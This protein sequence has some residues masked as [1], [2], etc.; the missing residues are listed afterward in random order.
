MATDKKKSLKEYIFIMAGVLLLA[1]S[2]K[3]FL[4]PNSLVTG[5]ATGL[6][7]IGQNI[8]QKYFGFTYPLWLSNLIIN[9]PLFIIAAK[10]LGVKFL[11]RTMFATFFLSAALYLVEF[12]PAL[13]MEND[14]L[15]SAVF[16]GALSGTGIGI[17]FANSATT[18]GSDIAAMLVHHYKKH[19]SVSK[20]L[21][22]MDAAVIV[23]GAFIFGLNKALY[24]IIYVFISS[25]M[26][27]TILEGLSFAKV[28]FIIS[29]YSQEIGEKLLTSLE[30]GVTALSGKGMYT[31]QAK[32]VVMCVV[33][34]KELVT[35]KTL[36]SETDKNAF[37]IV[38]D[39]REVLG[40]GFKPS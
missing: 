24:A 2:I 32:N 11:R 22:F 5:G 37:V 10:V 14:L 40:E 30:R 28:A 21:F 20:I 1:F 3:K 8:A 27:N 23:T 38:S 9:A 6:G 15:L 12:I 26:V 29:D 33:S 18:G 34:T 31:G 7:I 19:I 35:L 16:G 13:P 17:T 39:V 36:V 25:K 4:E